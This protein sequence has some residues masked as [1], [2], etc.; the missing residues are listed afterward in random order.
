MQLADDL[1]AGLPMVSMVRHAAEQPAGRAVE[2]DLVHHR[3]VAGYDDANEVEC[4][5]GHQ[6]SAAAMPIAKPSSASQT[7]QEPRPPLARDSCPAGGLLF[8]LMRSDQLSPVL[9][10]P[11]VARVPRLLKLSVAPG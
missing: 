7:S 6:I 9:G 8:A 3:L 10:K 1:D 2:P 4:G 5:R 11:T